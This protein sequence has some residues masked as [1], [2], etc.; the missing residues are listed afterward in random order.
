MSITE[1][2]FQ[3]LDKRLRDREDKA[4]N[5]WSQDFDIDWDTAGFDLD[6]LQA[7]KGEIKNQIR[8][9]LEQVKEYVAKNNSTDEKEISEHLGIT[10]SDVLWLL[11]TLS[12]IGLLPDDIK[13]RIK[14]EEN[15]F[16]Q[17]ISKAK[18]YILKTGN[19]SV[20]DIAE[21][22]K[23][24]EENAEKVLFALKSV[25]ELPSYDDEDEEEDINEKFEELKTAFEELK[26]EIG[27]TFDDA[28]PSDIP[29]EDVFDDFLKTLKLLGNSALKASEMIYDVIDK[30]MEQLKS[31]TNEKKQEE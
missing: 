15:L 17:N 5:E 1:V 20:Q 3:E 9:Y 24:S 31:K 10:E 6:F 30:S 4:W 29:C 16:R 25:G 14:E 11:E 27:T 8:K 18:E 28:N 21:E 13:N 26:E 23:I 19:D 7:A 2:V 22:L 12:D